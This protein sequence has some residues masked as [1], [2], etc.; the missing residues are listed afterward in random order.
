M[1]NIHLASQFLQSFDPGEKVGI[2]WLGTLTTSAKF[3]ERRTVHNTNL[4]PGILHLHAE[5][6]CSVSEKHLFKY[7]FTSASRWN[8]V[9]CSVVSSSKLY[10]CFI[11]FTHEMGLYHFQG[12]T[13]NEVELKTFIYLQL[14][15]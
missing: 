2:S 15:F 11:L 3:S 4:S 6:H 7:C 1:Q 5:N 9:F 12:C 14:C 8:H 10:F 13:L